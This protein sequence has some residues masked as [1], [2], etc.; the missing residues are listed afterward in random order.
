MSLSR[1]LAF[2]G[3]SP[4][5]RWQLWRYRRLLLAAV[6]IACTGYLP[7]RLAIAQALAPTPQAVLTLGGRAS[8]EAF[9]AEFARQH[10]DLPIWVSSGLKPQQSQLIFRSAQVPAAQV[11]LD[12]R[13]VDTVTNFTTLVADLERQNIHHVYLITSDFHMRRASAIATVV[14][15]S[16]GITF[17]PVSVPSGE[18][19]EDL[20][21]VGRDVIRACI[22]VLTGWTGADLNPNLPTGRGFQP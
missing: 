18:A 11:R 15:G 17:T 13:A 12:Y 5:W 20:L 6:L 1:S 10:P 7:A 4:H 19:P 8:R 22:W 2:P 16:R 14:L 3:L 21:R 9:T